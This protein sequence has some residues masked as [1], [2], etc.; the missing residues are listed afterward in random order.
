MC[1]SLGISPNILPSENLPVTNHQHGPPAAFHGEGGWTE[2]Q[3]ETKFLEKHRKHNKGPVLTKHKH[4]QLGSWFLRGGS[5]PTS[6]YS[7]ASMSENT[8]KRFKGRLNNFHLQTH[9][10]HYATTRFKLPLES[11]FQQA[12]LFHT[13]GLLSFVLVAPQEF[14]SCS[15]WTFEALL[16]VSIISASTRSVIQTN[17]WDLIWSITIYYLS[18]FDPPEVPY[19]VGQTIQH[20]IQ[21]VDF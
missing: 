19:F 18:T 5:Q 13:A 21:A 20:G 11:Q 6:R 12:F 16:L 1:A 4:L 15:H 8:N 17:D 7:N 9:K 3:S 2:F 10:R 14:T